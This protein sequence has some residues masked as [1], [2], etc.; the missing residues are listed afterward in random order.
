MKENFEKCLEM[1][2]HHEGGY[3]N[4]PKDPG[5]ETNLG[6]TKRVYEEWG[7]TKDM[8]S[9][10]VEDVA[11]IYKTKYWDLVK[12]DDLPHGVDWCTFDWAV[13]SGASRSAKAIQKIVGA[14]PDGVI[15]PKTLALIAKQDP[16][17]MVQEF[18]K[19]RQDFYESL[20]TFETFGR[21]WTTRN[22]E[23]TDSALNLIK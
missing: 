19:L 2:L 13:N 7:G 6:V 8:K 18:F 23:T 15:G 10:T 11:P 14:N 12:G 4:H 21:G 16:R 20:D 9:L 17:F 1:L 3:V 22:K 5:G